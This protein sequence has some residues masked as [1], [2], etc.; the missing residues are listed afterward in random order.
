MHHC[1]K[2]SVG[3]VIFGARSSLAHLN[4]SLGP[5]FAADQQ[6]WDQQCSFAADQFAIGGKK[7]YKAP[8]VSPLPHALSLSLSLSLSLFL[9]FLL[10]GKEG[11]MVQ[12]VI[13]RVPMRGRILKA[14]W[15]LNWAQFPTGSLSWSITNC[16]SIT[17][18]QETLWLVRCHLWH[19]ISA[20]IAWS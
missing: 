2:S 15:C 5:C 16:T 3:S 19:K 6:I 7:K 12:Q 13:P 4:S 11:I 9:S 14:H 1:K 18:E 20:I 17:M 10:T 8:A